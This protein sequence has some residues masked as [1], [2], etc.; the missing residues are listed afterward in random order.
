MTWAASP[1]ASYSVT[2]P[3]GADGI[4]FAVQN[5]PTYTN[6]STGTTNL[7]GANAVGG[8]GSALG[9][10]QDA[11]GFYLNR[12]A[13][14]VLDI[15]HSTIGF[16]SPVQSSGSGNAPTY[17]V[18]GSEPYLNSYTGQV[19]T[20]TYSGPAQTYTET[21]FD[22]GAYAA[23]GTT[24]SV[25]TYTYTTTESGLDLAA[26]LGGTAGGTGGGYIGFT[27]ATG[28]ISANQNVSSFTFTNFLPTAVSTL[29]NSIV[30]T[31]A[32]LRSCR[33]VLPRGLLPATW[34]A[35]LWAPVRR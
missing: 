20:I 3:E 25:S 5:T 2:P 14:A 23:A 12:S 28:G 7:G 16:P 35:L 26:L 29:A 11:N 24:A 21:V 34:A 30:T 13:G 10:A 31:R 1:R 18:S 19:V 6:A 9:Y 27:A 32:P 15:Y 8:T 17:N 4:T 33:S 22:A